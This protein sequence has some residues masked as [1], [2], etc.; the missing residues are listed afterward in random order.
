M[1]MVSL[2]SRDSRVEE[3][4]NSGDEIWRLSYAEM[5]LSCFFA[6]EKEENLGGGLR[7]RNECVGFGVC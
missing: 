7:S 1:A 6:S 2:M 3:N 4:T 5:S